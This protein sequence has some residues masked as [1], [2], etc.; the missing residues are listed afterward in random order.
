MKPAFTTK[1]AIWERE[2]MG[3]HRRFV[4][5]QCSGGWGGWR[6]F[7]TGGFGEATTTT[8]TYQ[9]GTLIVDLFEPKTR[10]LVWRASA[11]DTL[12]D[13]SDKNI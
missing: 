5:C 8:E 9:T 11:T 4:S 6:G 12:S 2:R 7:G 3:N 1:S 13:K 10:S